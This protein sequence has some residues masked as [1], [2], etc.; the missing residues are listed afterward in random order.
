MSG[1]ATNQDL[2]TRVVLISCQETKVN[3]PD[4]SIRALE[5]GWSDKETPTRFQPAFIVVTTCAT[6]REEFHKK[7]L[8]TLRSYGWK[9]SGVEQANPVAK[10][11]ESGDE[12]QDMLARTRTNPN[13]ISYGSVHSYS[14]TGIS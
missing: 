13:A 1:C 11:G 8:R 4:I 3:Q 10:E 6:S 12:V 7:C 2:F 14:V 9:L 5:I